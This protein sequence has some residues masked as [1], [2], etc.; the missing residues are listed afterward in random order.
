MKPMSSSFRPVHCNRGIVLP[1]LVSGRDECWI[2]K[3]ESE[4]IFEGNVIVGLHGSLL[5]SMEMFQA[6]IEIQSVATRE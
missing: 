6:G 5:K 2:G 4:S 3:L 1:T